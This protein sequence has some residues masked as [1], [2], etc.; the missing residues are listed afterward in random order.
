[1]GKSHLSRLHFVLVWAAAQV[2]GRDL[3]LDLNLSDGSWVVCKW[4]SAGGV[5]LN[6]LY[7]MRGGK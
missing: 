5:E 6:K 2:V 1:M 3:R 7:E 4:R